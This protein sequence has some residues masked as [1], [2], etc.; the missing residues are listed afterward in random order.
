MARTARNKPGE[1]KI[2][3]TAPEGTEVLDNIQ[4]AYE[5]NKKRINTALIVI[6]LVVGGYFAYKNLYQAPRNDKASAM[7]YYANRYFQSDSV[8]KA[9]NGDGQHKGYLAV[10]KKYG[11]TDAGNLS[12]YFAGVCYLKKG[13]NKNAIK[14]LKDFKGKGTLAGYTAYGALGDAYMNSG[15][16]KEAAENY[17]KA[18]GKTDNDLHNPI[19]LF[20]AG[21]AYEKLNKVDEAKKMYRKIRDE[22]PRSQEGQK[23][24]KQLASLGELE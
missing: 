15:N 8:D 3:T 1:E 5:K 20:R 24:E 7:M 6:V 17:E 11:S 21:L 19:Y 18:A 4:V 13:D 23:V 22:Y 10:I 9:L 16:V 14:Y 12:K 2:T